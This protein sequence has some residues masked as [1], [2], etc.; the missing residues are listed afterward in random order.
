MRNRKWTKGEIFLYKHPVTCKL[1]KMFF[2]IL[3]LIIFW[4]VACNSCERDDK[5]YQ[6]WK[7]SR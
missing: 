4:M 6:I 1:F 7:E 3:F 5:N 2:S